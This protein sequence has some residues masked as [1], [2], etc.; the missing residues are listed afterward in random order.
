MPTSVFIPLRPKTRDA[1]ITALGGVYRVNVR[2]KLASGELFRRQARCRSKGEARTRRDAFYEEFNIVE[3]GSAHRQTLVVR[4]DGPTLAEWTRACVEAH[5]PRTVPATVRDYAASMRDHVLPVLGDLSLSQ[6]EPNAIRAFLHGLADK[7]VSR[8]GKG[9]DASGRAKLSVSSLKAARTALSSALNLAVEHGLIPKNP[10][11]GLRVRWE[12]IAKGRR[13]HDASLEHDDAPEKRLLTA[14]EVEAALVAAQGTPAHALILLQSRLGLRVSEALGLHTRDFDLEAG[15]VLVHRQ[16]QRVEN[17]GGGSRLALV[18]LKTKRA[19]RTI[20]VPASV[21]RFVTSL[22]DGPVVRNGLGGW[23]EPRAAQT[24]LARAF[25]RAG[26]CGVPG[27]PDP[28]SH[29]LRFHFVSHLLNDRRVPVTVV[30][31]LAGHADVSTTLRYY[32]EATDENLRDAMA[33]FD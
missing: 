10:A 24:S 25:E 15:T 2:L 18:E 9:G 14:T 3:G 29:D 31:R 16:L 22:D 28:T 1:N 5:W 32:S 11:L 12:A 7:E 6:I 17:E 27:Q 19:R 30:S 20:P 33:C 13:R 4:E 26:L 8:S 23:L 21:R